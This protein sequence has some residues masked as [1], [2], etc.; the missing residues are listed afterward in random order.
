[1]R[2]TL[3]NFSLRQGSAQT[4]PTIALE[5]ERHVIEHL[6][7]P[8]SWVRVLLAWGPYFQRAAAA[9]NNVSWDPPLEIVTDWEP[10]EPGWIAATTCDAGAGVI[11][12]GWPSPKSDLPIA[13]GGVGCRASQALLW[14]DGIHPTAPGRDAHCYSFTAHGRASVSVSPAAELS[15][16]CW[17]PDGTPMGMWQPA[18]RPTVQQQ[19]RSL[20]AAGSTYWVVAG[21]TDAPPG[22]PGRTAR[23]SGRVVVVHAQVE[24][25]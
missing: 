8:Q 24:P 11:T 14:T 3:T 20:A 21:A 18:S 22:A 1:M 13:C 16:A 5:A 7:G 4:L 12:A 17:L 9:G 6:V 15:A 19:L 25:L 10:P 23:G 2:D